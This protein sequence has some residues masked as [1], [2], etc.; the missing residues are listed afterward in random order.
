MD[1]LIGAVL[2]I[3][4]GVYF[5]KRSQDD[6]GSGGSGGGNGGPSDGGN[7]NLK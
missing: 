4:V 3:A 1:M 7:Q 2:I 6:N 5:W